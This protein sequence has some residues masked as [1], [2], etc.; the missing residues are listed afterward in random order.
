MLGKQ[1][2]YD[3]KWI[4]KVIIVF[5]ALAIVFSIISRICLNIENSL[6]FKIIGQISSGITIAMIINSLLNGIIRSWVRFIRNIYKDESYLTHTLPVEKKT[7]YQSK[8][9]S[10]IITTFITIIVSIICLYICFGT[11]ENLE[12]LKQMLDLVANTYSTTVIKILFA[13]SFIFFLEIVFVIL[14]GYT[15]IIIGHKSNRNK[16][17]ISIVVGFGLY[18]ITSM[19]SLLALC[20]VGF[21]NQDIMNIVITEGSITEG[22]IKIV[23]ILAMSV[24][25]IYDIVYYIARKKI[26]RSRCKC[27]I[28]IL[29]KQVFT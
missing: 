24:Y 16:M 26:T 23:I 25:L 8:V 13:I 27:R 14:I 28:K 21:L 15:G 20:V 1:I 17:P 19:I 2:K 10:A 12:I 6:L 5:Y 7:I 18:M 29:A 11:K 4:Y 22:A 9:I 3:L